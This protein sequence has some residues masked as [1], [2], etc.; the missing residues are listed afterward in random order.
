[1]RFSYSTS[2]EG[3]YLNSKKS[4]KYWLKKL[5][6]DIL[7][8]MNDERT[9]LIQDIQSLIADL[10]TNNQMSNDAKVSIARRIINLLGDNSECILEIK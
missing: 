7:F 2:L 9:L 10:L 6:S 5:S 4:K 1:M 3:E 8:I